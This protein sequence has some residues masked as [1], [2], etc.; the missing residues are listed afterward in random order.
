MMIAVYVTGLWLQVDASRR[1]SDPRKSTKRRRSLCGLEV[2]PAKPKGLERMCSEG[3]YPLSDSSGR[4]MWGKRPGQLIHNQKYY[5]GGYDSCT[6]TRRWYARTAARNFTLPREN[7]NSM[8]KKGSKTSRRGARHAVRH[9]SQIALPT[10]VNREKCL[11]Q[12]ARL[13]VRRRASHSFP[14]TTV[15]FTAATASPPVG[16]PL[17]YGLIYPHDV[18]TC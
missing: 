11:T 18:N 1:R 8:R 13:A 15:P 17:G 12:P 6:R 14:K 10:V 4:R 16:N 3:G 9:A 2:S 7:R 5:S